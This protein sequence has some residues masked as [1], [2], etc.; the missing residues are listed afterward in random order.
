MQGM[1]SLS[2]M[3]D[4]MGSQAIEHLRIGD[5]QSWPVLVVLHSTQ[6]VL[7]SATRY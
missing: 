5:R 3:L 1:R 2:I 6:I 4:E 7:M